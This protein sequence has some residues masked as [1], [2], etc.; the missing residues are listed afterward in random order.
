MAINNI[1]DNSDGDNDG[2][3]AANWSL[4]RVPTIG[5]IAYF[6]GTGGDEDADCNFSGNLT[7]DGINVTSDYSGE[8]SFFKT[9]VVS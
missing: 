6:R 3:V 9:R 4:N 8:F 1:W 2:N 7:C 5:D